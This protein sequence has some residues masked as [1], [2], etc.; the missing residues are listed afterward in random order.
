[1]ETFLDSLPIGVFG[2]ADVVAAEV[3]FAQVAFMLCLLSIN[4][5][6]FLLLMLRL[7]DDRLSFP[8]V[9]NGL[10]LSEGQADS[11]SLVF[12]VDA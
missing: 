4:L 2:L 1:M 5:L 10:S 11:F 6:T 12:T 8:T 3:L 9:D 7:L